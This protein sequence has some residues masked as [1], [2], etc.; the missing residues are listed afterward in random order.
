MLF[1]IQS[2]EGG[3]TR[4]STLFLSGRTRPSTLFLS[5]KIHHSDWLVIKLLSF[6]WLDASGHSEIEWLDT[7]DHSIS[8]WP[9]ASDQSKDSN[10]ITSQS[11]W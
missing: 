8:E 6:D 11:E 9:D 4:P 2:V 10:F 7:S 5:G 1:I 3:R